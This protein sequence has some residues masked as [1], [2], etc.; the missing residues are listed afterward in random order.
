MPPASWAVGIRFEGFVAWYL[1]CMVLTASEINKLT[2]EEI[3][4][5]SDEGLDSEGPVRSLRQR[6]VPHFSMSTMSSKQ[7]V[8]SLQRTW[9]FPHWAYVRMIRDH[10]SL[11]SRYSDICFCHWSEWPGSLGCVKSTC[12]GGIDPGIV[13][14]CWIQ[15]SVIIQRKGRNAFLFGSEMRLLAE[16][17]IPLT[18]KEVFLF[19][20]EM[21]F[22]RAHHSAYR[23]GYLTVWVGCE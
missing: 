20:S 13:M 1:C 2:A 12:V 9:F 5:C 23:R 14:G 22:C 18:R 16:R 6:L 21:R 10:V 11:I 7:Y 4:I 8:D 19:G 17:I 3:R 15:L